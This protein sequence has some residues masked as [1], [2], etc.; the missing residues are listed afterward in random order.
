MFVVLTRV[1]V[2]TL[3]NQSFLL[4]Y[5]FLQQDYVLIYSV[6]NRPV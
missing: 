1:T 6:L 4:S 5:M 2:Y 3:R